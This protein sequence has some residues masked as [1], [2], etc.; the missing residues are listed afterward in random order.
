MEGDQQ[1]DRCL[2]NSVLCF[3]Y[4]DRTL[5]AFHGLTTKEYTLLFPGFFSENR[6]RALLSTEATHLN[7]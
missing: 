5:L 2:M 7:F 6:L 1:A 3:G 4:R